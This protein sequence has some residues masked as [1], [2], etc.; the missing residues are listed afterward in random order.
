[1]KL[2]VQ[3]LFCCL[4]FNGVIFSM[5]GTRIPRKSNN[6]I[7]YETTHIKQDVVAVAAKLGPKS[8]PF[9]L[10]RAPSFQASLE[11]KVL[12]VDPSAWHKPSRFLHVLPQLVHELTHLELDHDYVSR[13][14]EV[15]ADTVNAIKTGI[16]G[17]AA[18]FFLRESKKK[19]NCLYP[20]PFQI[21]PSRL[22]RARYFFDLHRKNRFKAEY[23]DGRLWKL[24]FMLTSYLQYKFHGDQEKLNS[25]DIKNTLELLST[26]KNEHHDVQVPDVNLVQSSLESFSREDFNYFN[27]ELRACK[28][29]ME[30]TTPQCLL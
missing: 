22:E 6:I 27:H 2:L 16:A 18:R 25:M 4:W 14:H 7:Y 11:G 28:K 15:Q 13:E 30:Q 17:D 29:I 12:Y 23:L 5:N 26:M 10:E 19:P 20:N 9:R 24:G 21:H 8:L 1:M 3:F